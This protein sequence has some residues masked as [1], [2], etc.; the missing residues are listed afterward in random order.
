MA[1]P[2]NVE[3]SVDQNFARFGSKSYAIN[4][5]NSVEVRKHQPHGLA[6]VIICAGLAI[7]L[8]GNGL[9]QL[10]SADGEPSTS[11]IIGVIFGGLAWLFAKRHQIVDY[12]LFLMTSSSEAQAFQSRNEQEV[13]QLRSAIEGAMAA[14]SRS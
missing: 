2:G 3:V 1:N 10:T 13:T 5:I 14:S 9:G 4:K 6:G 8:L 11:I 7:I 12:Q